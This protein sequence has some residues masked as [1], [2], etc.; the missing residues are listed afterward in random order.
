MRGTDLFLGQTTA[1]DQE[2]PRVEQSVLTTEADY[3]SE[4]GIRHKSC[5]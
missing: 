1:N 4:G 5:C 3:F 2:I